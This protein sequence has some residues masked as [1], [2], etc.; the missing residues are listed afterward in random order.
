MVLPHMP[1][2]KAGWDYSR[3]AAAPDQKLI[4]IPQSS[5]TRPL[6]DPW[7]VAA[8]QEVKARLGLR[9]QSTQ[10]ASQHGLVVLVGQEGAQGEQGSRVPLDDKN[11]FPELPGRSFSANGHAAIAKQVQEPD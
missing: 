7:L 10:G 8:E 5:T 2:G 6:K 1:A 3:A 11:E 4:G 9:M